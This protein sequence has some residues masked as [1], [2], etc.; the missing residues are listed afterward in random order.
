[1]DAGKSLL[2]SSLPSPSY[3][4]R[5]HFRNPVSTSVQML[6]EHT[7][8]VV[9]SM[10]T[11]STLRHF[12]TSV[13]SLEQ[14]EDYKGHYFLKDEKVAQET[15]DRQQLETGTSSCEE[16]EEQEFDQYRKY[17]ER[18]MLYQ[19]GFWL[20]PTCSKENPI[21]VSTEELIAHEN[22]ATI[23]NGAKEFENSANSVTPDDVLALAKR[24]MMAT[25]KAAVLAEK[26]SILAAELNEPHF[27]GADP[28]EFCKDI[29]TREEVII[30]SKRISERRPK[31]RKVSKNLDNFIYDVPSLKNTNMSKKIDKSID[32]N[33]PLRLFLWGPETKQ[34]LTIKEEKELFVQ[35]QDLIR[36]EEVKQRLSVQF[37]REPTL[38]EWAQAVGMS[39]QDLQS[40]LYSGKR[41]REKMINGNLRL[42]V[43]VAKQYEGK[44]LNI[45]DLLQEGS[46]GLMRSLEKFKPK[47]GCRF[48]TYAY[49]WIR[50]SIRKAIFQ[51]SRTVRLPENVF[52]VLKKIK[53]ARRL[54]LQEGHLPTYEDIARRVGITTERLRS[55]LLTSRK[56]VSIQER[57]WSDQDVTFQEI[58]ADPEV[59]VPDLK[60]T[61]MMMR[62]HVVDL[63]R[64]LKPRER[65]I[66]LYRFGIHDG[67]R[68][69]L[70]EIGNMFGLSKER[71]RQIE[72]QALEKLKASLP[73]QGLEAYMELI[74]QG[75]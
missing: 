60:I 15:L 61:K 17:F 75:I 7:S 74:I 30:R 68:K 27:H 19:S 47:A 34:L 72:S 28:K 18:Q 49:W 24:A 8:R 33:D 29:L 45:Q 55:L 32:L 48:S 36:L 59:E 31:K 2:S 51:N 56:P 43:H 5:T 67:E 63:L 69:S 20:P 4:P 16:N 21:S 57:P 6:H 13:L 1:M 26:S 64:I 52:A 62:Q 65:T 71:V 53:T 38:A 22:T 10:P 25:R 35:I 9:A 58:T 44:G 12:P 66:I 73:S 46:R 23:E 14:R 40:R 41:S 11:S 39:C 42:V 54:Y 3:L 50:Q 37:A 70:T